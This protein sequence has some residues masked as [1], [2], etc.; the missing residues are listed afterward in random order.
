MTQNVKRG[1]CRLN[2]CRGV[3]TMQ[4]DDD[5]RSYLEQMAKL[6][7]PPAWELP[8]DVVRSNIRALHLPHAAS[9]RPVGK[10][11]DRALKGPRGDLP[12]RIYWPV[13]AREGLPLVV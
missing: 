11:E 5:I 1:S 4:P 13:D 8:L 7:L 3:S 10:V 12:V 9:P 6:E 2:S